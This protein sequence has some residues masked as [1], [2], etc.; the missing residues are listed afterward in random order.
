M[1][2]A[3]QGIIIMSYLSPHPQVASSALP[4]CAVVVYDWKTCTFQEL[5]R[6]V[7]R[8]IGASK[9]LSIAVVAPGNKPGCLG[10]LI[11]SFEFVCVLR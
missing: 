9:V 8:T 11:M 4:H 2:G 5:I 6:M 7:K 1:D 3:H 10:E